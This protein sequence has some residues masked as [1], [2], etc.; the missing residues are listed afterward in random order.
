MDPGPGGDAGNPK[1]GAPGTI[2]VRGAAK[3]APGENLSATGACG[4][5][6]AGLSVLGAG[7]GWMVTLQVYAVHL[8]DPRDG[9]EDSPVLC[10][11]AQLQR[12]PRG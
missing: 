10:P 3:G 4:A 9:D 12:L 1:E 7:M 8:E 6:G 2:P 5:G 11:G